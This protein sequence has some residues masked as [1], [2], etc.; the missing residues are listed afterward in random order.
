MISGHY[1]KICFK[2]L[3]NQETTLF[4]VV[5]FEVSNRVSGDDEVD[6]YITRLDD[7]CLMITALS[8]H[9]FKRRLV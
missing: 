7:N 4:R 6:Q 2:S 5:K 9:W 3:R 1:T 8:L